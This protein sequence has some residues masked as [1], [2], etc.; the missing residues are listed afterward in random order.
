MARH[1]TK[2]PELLALIREHGP[3]SPNRLTELTGDFRQ[4]I[5][6]YIRQAHE[7]ELIHVAAFEP[8]PLGGNRTVKLYA[9]GAGKDAQRPYVHQ[10]HQKRA[11]EKRKQEPV[12][13]TAEPAKTIAIV[14]SEH[15][16]VEP[17]S[18][19][20]SPEEDS[21]LLEIYSNQRA[22][23]HQL[24]RLPGRSYPAV[25]ARAARLKLDHKKPI[26]DGSLSWIKPAII[27]ALSKS[28]SMTVADL[29]RVTGATRAGM[30]PVIRRWRGV[31]WHIAGWERV[32]VHGWL[33]MW[34]LGNEMDEPKPQ[35]K[36]MT[37]A[38]RE[39]RQRQRIAQGRTNPF[40][41]IAGFV[42]IPEGQRGRVF[43]QSM[44]I[45]DDEME[46]AA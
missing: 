17:K 5:D 6:K 16:A 39:W 7:D 23:K 9:I 12:K 13:V 42:S 29:E 25:K 40:A 10:K 35:P 38:C 33:P 41:S 3:V 32:G 46:C 43:Q 4:S 26:T 22:V 37:Q 19:E 15:I 20:W 14:I 27:A 24:S 31:D 18:G 8:S 30:K 36:S 2:I 45:E 44:S 1:H 21:V 28:G 11:A 34:A